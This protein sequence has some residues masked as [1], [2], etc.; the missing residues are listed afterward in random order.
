MLFIKIQELEF[1]IN[2]KIRNAFEEDFI[3]ISQLGEKCSPIN[4]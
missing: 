1:L 3:K 2:F 4:K